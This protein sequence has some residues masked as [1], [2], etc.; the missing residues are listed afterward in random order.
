MS[1]ITFA[2]NASRV[3]LENA[4]QS[5]NFQSNEINLA[6]ASA[7]SVHAVTTGSA[8]GSFYLSASVDGTSWVLIPNST[9]AVSG[10]DTVL[11]NVKSAGYLMA[12]LH[13]VFS[14]GTGTADAS[15]A[16]KEA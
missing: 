9:Q 3:L 11:Y 4:D 7:F 12:R 6:N 2:N 5:A 8:A 15:F 13:W 16:V 14:S 1:T 10:G